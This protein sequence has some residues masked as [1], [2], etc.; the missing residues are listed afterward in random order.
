MYSTILKPR[1]I[2]GTPK[3]LKCTFRIWS[4]YNSSVRDVRALMIVNRTANSGI[5]KHSFWDDPV[6]DLLS[7]L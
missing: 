5:R 4:A 7:Y 6:G 3:Q 2:H 1:K